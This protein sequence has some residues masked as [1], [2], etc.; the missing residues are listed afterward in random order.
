MRRIL[1]IIVACLIL[2][3]VSYYFRNCSFIE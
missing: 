1:L 3:V 2:R